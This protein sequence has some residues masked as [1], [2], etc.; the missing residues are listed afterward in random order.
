MGILQEPNV[1]QEKSNPSIS[2][3]SVQSWSVA[4]TT[5]KNIISHLQ[6]SLFSDRRRIQVINFI[7]S[8]IKRFC[9]IE[10]LPYGS[11]PLKTYLPDG[12]ID[13][14]AFAGANFEEAVAN[15]IVS[16]LQ[17]LEKDSNAEFLVKE[18]RLIHA[19]VKLVKCLVQNIVVD[20]SFNQ[21]GGLCTLCFLE[22]VDRVIGKDHLFK[23]SIL[24]IKA[25][26]YYE[27]RVLGAHHGLISTY[28][29]ETLV[30][31]I[32]Q[33]FHST[34]DG[35]LAVLYKFLDYFSKFDWKN[36]CI[37]LSGPVRLSSLPEFE[38]ELPEN[39]GGGLLLTEDFYRHCLEAFTV[40][41]KG[42]EMQMGTF[43]KKH[44]NIVDP[45]K[46][47]NNLGRSVSE[48]NFY[49]IKS[50]FT[51]GARKL[52]QILLLSGDSI[53]AELRTFFSN[54]LDRHGSGP[55]PDVGDF[56]N[57]L[58][59]S[60]THSATS[61][62]GSESNQE[63]EDGVCILTALDPEMNFRTVN[64]KQTGSMHLSTDIDVSATG[65]NA[66]NTKCHLSVDAE[67][68][69]MSRM[70]GLQIQNES[71][72]N[73][74]TYKEKTDFQERK[75]Q[76]APHLYFC[77]P[78]VGC[79]KSK[80]EESNITQSEDRDKRVS[81]DVLQELDEGRATNNGHDHGS[82][83]QRPVR[84][85]N[86]PSADSVAVNG[87]LA[88]ANNPASPESSDSSLDLLG[89][90]DAHFHC[91]RY[92]QWF[93]E[94]G[95]TMQ[96][97]P[98]PLPPLPPPPPL[99]IY[100]MN[101]WD[102]IQ[103]S[104]LQNV[105]PN[106]NVNGLVHSPGFCPPINSMVMPHAS[107]SFEEMPKPRGTGT[108]F[109]NL[110]YTPRGYRPSAVKGRIKAPVRSH[111]SNGQTSRFTEF[112]VEQNGGMLGHLDGHQSDPWRNI[113][114]AIVQP[115]GV[116]EFRPFLHA[117]PG[118]PFQESSRQPRPDSLPESV[119]PGIPTP[120][121]LSPGAVVGLDD[122]RSTQPSSYS[123]YLK[124]EDDFPPLSI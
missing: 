90:F 5:T 119:K 6:P 95:S 96:A 104:S 99:H 37:T 28:A 14:T 84:S 107:Y 68:D 36:Y 117:L 43:A 35:P 113:N 82:E 45:L 78:S 34:L 76:Y 58:A 111:N 106:G 56:I 41:L 27:S 79:G 103:H 108:Y 49:R 61:T 98:V 123:Y 64:G 20:I 81:Y 122:V 53:A 110:N 29:L 51:F 87:S 66:P 11:V 54:T 91:L 101:S 94:V 118:A 33:V 93:L 60:V 21:I 46:E 16:E 3:I 18:I 4:D 62:L 115:S 31:Y 52:G 57:M 42:V 19:E 80:C 86:V 67:E 10:V 26:C 100:S 22:Q 7:H 13:L 85:V 120:G 75:P 59:P 1:E 69:A 97:W 50:A 70:Q 114:G 88:S 73:P 77:K 23:R 71:Q 74:S 72:N 38:T 9:Q 65:S 2:D 24:L 17:R 83:V 47:F 39:V 92:G 32:F 63:D 102:A 44:L 40:P 105:F 25:W 8:L 89:D 121:I 55:R 30:L 12:D 116:V 109:P 112:P 48:G 15:D 124:D